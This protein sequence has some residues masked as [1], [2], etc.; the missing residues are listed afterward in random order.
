MDETGRHMHTI[1][2]MSSENVT[3]YL[4][5]GSSRIDQSKRLRSSWSPLVA[6]VA[7]GFDKLLQAMTRDAACEH[8]SR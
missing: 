5:L 1:Y 2:I 3:R 8:S 7:R 6:L 4:I